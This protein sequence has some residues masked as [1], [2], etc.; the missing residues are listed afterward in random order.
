ME[1]AGAQCREEMQRQSMQSAY[2]E[3]LAQLLWGFK[4]AYDEW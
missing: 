4:L 3:K 1:G 2:S